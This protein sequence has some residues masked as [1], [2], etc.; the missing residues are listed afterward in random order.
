MKSGIAAALALAAFLPSAALASGG[1]ESF[2]E[3]DQNGDGT[4]SA[5]E[6]QSILSTSFLYFDTNHD[7]YIDDYDFS[8]DDVDEEGVDGSIAVDFGD[9]D[10]DNR[11]SLAEFTSRTD[12]W[13]AVM[14]RNGDGLV[15]L[16]DFGGDGF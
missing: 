12:D 6:V 14:D 7:G 11:V 5:G 8:D 4:I 1:A 13:I 10:G 9:S 16:D 3:W 2:N 15:K